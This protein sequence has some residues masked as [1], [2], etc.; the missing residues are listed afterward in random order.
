MKRIRLVHVAFAAL[1]VALAV[2]AS[3]VSKGAPACRRGRARRGQAHDGRV[4]GLHRREVGQAVRAADRLQGDREVRRQLERHVQPDDVRRRRPV[5]PGLGLRRREP[6]AHRRRAVAEVNVKLI[7]ALQGL[8]QGLQVAGEQHGGRASTTAS[9]CSRTQ[10][11]ALQ[12]SK[13]SSRSRRPGRRSTTRSTRARSRSRTTRS[14]SP[15]RRST[16]RRRSHRS[17]SRTVRADEGPARRRSSPCSS[18]SGR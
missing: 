1:V 2:P 9:R 18:S 16:S 11:A 8:L 15:T 7:P 6:P 5:R 3:G 17:A 12:H 13:I 4:G 10:R 14:R